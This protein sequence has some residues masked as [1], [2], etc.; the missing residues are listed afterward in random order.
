MKDR[1]HTE[2]F[3][4]KVRM[5]VDPHVD[6]VS[7]NSARYWIDRSLDS[8]YD[9]KVGGDEFYAIAKIIQGGPSFEDDLQWRLIQRLNGVEQT[10]SIMGPASG[11]TLHCLYEAYDV[12][13][14]VGRLD[15][16]LFQA[17]SNIKLS[18]SLKLAEQ[19]VEATV[20]KATAIKKSLD[21]A[22][23]IDEIL[24]RVSRED[25]DVLVDSASRH[26]DLPGALKSLVD[27]NFME[28]WA[29][30][31]VES[32]RDSVKGFAYFNKP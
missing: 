15:E 26:T 27:E 13:I 20:T 17:R 24:K 3:S 25:P 30:Q 29:G 22:G 19:L 1:L 5:I 9:D 7:K 32:F 31:V 11:K 4:D 16:Y 14:T 8:T 23:W 12:G 2:I 18:K 6:S 21:Q 10:G 28:E